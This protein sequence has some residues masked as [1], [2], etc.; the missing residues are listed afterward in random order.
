MVKK[1]KMDMPSIR[2]FGPDI[3][4]MFDE[5]GGPN[6]YV[7]TFPNVLRKAYKTYTQSDPTEDYEITIAGAGVLRMKY[8][9]YEF[10]PE[11][12]YRPRVGNRPLK[13]RW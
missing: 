4:Y 10:E 5:V 8:R 2:E 7:M 9:D 6:K 12:Q 13:G 3:G 1:V 11:P